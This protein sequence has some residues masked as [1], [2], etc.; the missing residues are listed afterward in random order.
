MSNNDDGD[1]D[2][3]SKTLHPEDMI[4]SFQHFRQQRPD[5]DEI[6]LGRAD[7]LRQLGDHRAA[8]RVEE[9]RATITHYWTKKPYRLG[10]CK[11][12]VDCPRCSDELASYYSEL[13]I[14]AIREMQAPI[15]TYFR[16]PS[17]K[18]S[19][20]ASTMTDLRWSITALRRQKCFRLVDRAF[21]MIEPKLAGR[22]W[23]WNVHAHMIFEPVVD[24]TAVDAAFK[25]LNSGRGEF[26]VDG[27][28]RS[29]HAV[30][31]YS[32]KRD[33]WCP[34]PGFAGTNM[35]LAKFGILRAAMRGRHLLIRWPRYP[36]R[37]T[38]FD[39]ENGAIDNTEQRY[40]Q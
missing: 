10:I 33:T 31:R 32:C 12:R 34:D 30:A 35:D 1:D 7:E 15:F 13:G 11:R 18:L 21:G 8:K 19:D 16:L 4:E 17:K 40:G 22:G 26:S 24:L 5:N 28:A 38:S 37:A 29:R 25:K 36:S 6:Q 27:A 14:N 3:K 20:L 23:H 39:L 9:C 2:T